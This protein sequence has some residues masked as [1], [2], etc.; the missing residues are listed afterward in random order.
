MRE[1]EI[2]LDMIESARQ[3]SVE[4]GML[5]NSIIRGRGNITGFIGEQ[6]AL[7]C[8]GGAL[9]N[10][11]D[12]DIVLPNGRTVDVKTKQTSVKPLPEYDCSVA[13]YNTKQ[14]CDFYAFVRVKGDLTVGWYLGM[15]E[16]ERYFEQA[17]FLT[18]GEVD[19]SNGYT[20]KADCYNVKIRDLNEI[21]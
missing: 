1:I 10:T 3:K 2:S 4:M 7:Q 9:N 6:V 15:I 12:Y 20:V 19:P 11:F 14:K 13:K 5:N 21:C 16:K 17:Q 18:K 8:L